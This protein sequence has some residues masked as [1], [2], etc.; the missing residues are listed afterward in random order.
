MCN[1]PDIETKSIQSLSTIYCGGAR[2]PPET[3]KTIRKY[4]AP[5]CTI[6]YGYGCT[7][8]GT[9]SVS[10]SDENPNSNGHLCD[11]VEVKI[12]SSEG[13]I[14]GTHENGE[15]NV[16]NGMPWEGYFGDQKATLDIY[17]PQEMWCRT[18]DL[19]HFD[20]DGHLYVV[21]RIK[22][23]LKTRGFQFSATEVEN[24]I[25]ENEDVEEVC[26]VGLHDDILVDV[27]GALV[28]IK[29]GSLLTEQNVEDY[30][31]LKTPFYKH[32]TGRVFF[33]ESLA[34]NSAGKVVRRLAREVCEQMY[35]KKLS[36]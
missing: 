17:D 8:I 4:L 30:V 22:D 16:R 12:V 11:N 14:V 9:I 28:V 29:K 10:R 21:D 20:N 1:S 23:I 13:D 24:V 15:I 32:V 2:L 33:V 3:R 5:S 27:P 31:A 6:E 19:G 34:R 7:E 26:V 36:P 25:T 18:G 35:K